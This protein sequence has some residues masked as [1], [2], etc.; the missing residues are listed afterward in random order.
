MLLLNSLVSEAKLI[1]VTSTATKYANKSFL[2]QLGGFFLTPLM[3][4][5]DVFGLD[6]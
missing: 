5:K 4:L 1:H 3:G 2:S 6:G